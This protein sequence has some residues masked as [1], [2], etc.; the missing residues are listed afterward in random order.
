MKH[1]IA[2]LLA[3]VLSTASGS[4]AEKEKLPLETELNLHAI[5]INSEGKAIDPSMAHQE[6]AGLPAGPEGLR[7]AARP[8]LRRD[9]GVEKSAPVPL[10]QRPHHGGFHGERRFV[11][12]LSDRGLDR[13]ARRRVRVRRLDPAGD[14]EVRYDAP[15]PHGLEFRHLSRRQSNLQTARVEPPPA[16][17]SRPSRKREGQAAPETGEQ[18]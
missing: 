10:R 11:S 17:P 18:E 8:H 4:A 9:R 5:A 14:A 13:R 16:R 15:A 2:P 6:E 1:H 12:P 7:G 3:L